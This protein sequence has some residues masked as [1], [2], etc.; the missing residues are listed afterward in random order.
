M[1]NNNY[2][3]TSTE[4]KNIIKAPEEAN[5]IGEF[6][7]ELPKGV[8]INKVTTG[9]G[10]TTVAIKSC[11]KYVICVPYKSMIVNKKKQH[12]EI[13]D[14]YGVNSGG[15]TDNNIK[16]YIGTTIMVTWDSL[17]RLMKFINVKE[18]NILIDEAHKLVDSGN[19]R[20]KVI[21][22]VLDNYRLFKTFSFMTA[23][24]VLKEYQLDELKEIPEVKIEWSGLK[25]VTIDKEIT[26]SVISK[27]STVAL[28]TIEDEKLG[29]LHVFINSVKDIVKITGKLI[30]AKV[31]KP[32]NRINIVCADNDSN[33]DYIH[34]ELGISYNIATVGEVKRINFYTSTAFEGS[35]IF[36]E[37]A[38]IYIA[39]TG[40]KNHTKINILT[41][42]PQIIG[43]IRNIENNNYVKLI[44]SPD[45]KEYDIS[46][47]EYR[48][49]INNLI[50]KADN[51]VKVYNKLEDDEPRQIM[52]KGLFENQFYKIHGDK[53]T[54]NKLL[55]KSKMHDFY[56]IR[57]VYK[58]KCRIL[59]STYKVNGISYN[60]KYDKE[61]VDETAVE[62]L[63][64]NNSKNFVEIAKEYCEL[65]K[66]HMSLI[67]NDKVKTSVNVIEKTYPFISEAYAV[68]G[69][70]GF[71]K[72]K[73]R[74]QAIKDAM[75]IESNNT[76]NKKKVKDLL[77]LEETKF[78]SNKEL[79]SQ[80]QRVYNKLKIK[81]TAKAS[82]ITEYYEIKKGQTRDK[83]KGY[84]ILS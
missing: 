61:P 19:F 43:R 56:T 26:G 32:F 4:I 81:K 72:A 27:I 62:R 48:Q 37:N 50:R 35:D 60:Y 3:S 31:E 36:D 8:L 13:L 39:V 69:E 30:K 42:L 41:T 21:Q 58:S 76:D 25:D 80:I 16:E 55:W 84:Y 17:E 66:D 78:Y 18:W 71:V 52:R 51:V 22:S 46:E 79:K 2:K 29:N 83:G 57:K 12:A 64:L 45:N 11:E 63:R 6:L 67:V 40:A 38:R 68:L 33:Q 1:I 34:N 10:G 65:M 75:I 23:T 73:Y 28:R 5:F 20:E 82:L 15:A 59:D 9:C 47:E 70:D 14:V 49:E 77:D 54:V 53:V 7:E 74:K 44:Y 24:P